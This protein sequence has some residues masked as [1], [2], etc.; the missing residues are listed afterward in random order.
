[1]RVGDRLWLTGLLLIDR[2]FGTRLAIKEVTRRRQRLAE[3]RAQL[4]DILSELKRL[5]GL[6]EQANVE[7]CLFCLRQRRVLIPERWLCFQTTDK[8]EARVLEMLIEHLVKPRLTAVE[9]Q[10]D[11]AGYTYRLIPDWTAIRSALKSPDPELVAWLEEMAGQS[12]NPCEGSKSSQ[13]LGS[14]EING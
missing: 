2:I 3:T 11:E 12:L 1:M 13:G 7:L 9:V 14:V 8:D 5:N 4:A 6:V 10:E